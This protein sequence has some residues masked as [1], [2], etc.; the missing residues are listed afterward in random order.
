M[1][2][3]I[4]VLF[5]MLTMVTTGNA[6]VIINMNQVGSDVVATTTGSLQLSGLTFLLAAPSQASAV[7]PLTGTLLVGGGANT[8][9][10]VYSGMLGPGPPI[11]SGTTTIFANSGSGGLVGFSNQYANWL[12]VPNG[13]TSG[14]PFTADSTWAKWN[15]ATIASLGLT[16][17]STYTWT[18]GS[19]ATADSLT[20]NV[21]ATAVPEPS[22]YALLCISLGVVGYARKKM[23]V[24]P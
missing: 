18:W 13:Y 7:N 17:G 1:K 16:S 11:G 20:L 14:T 12:A 19:G 5:M 6:S 2:R 4:W 8:I 3:C 24:K 22:T 15:N 9:V 21:N 10:D 23:A